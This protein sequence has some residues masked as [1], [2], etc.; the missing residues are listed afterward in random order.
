MKH[1]VIIN[2]QEVEFIAKDE[3]IFCTSLDVAMVFEK[4]HFHI[5]RY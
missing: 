2:K 4:R 3:S 1:L 5:L